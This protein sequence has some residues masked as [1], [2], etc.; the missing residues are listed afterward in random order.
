[1]KRIIKAINTIVI[2]MLV[3]SAALAHNP[4]FKAFEVDFKPNKNQGILTTDKVN[5]G[6]NNG[7]GLK[8]GCIKFPLD[9]IG[10]ITFALRNKVNN[11]NDSGTQ[12]VITK[13]ELSHQGFDL[14]G[15]TISD[16]GIFEGN[17][18]PWLV[19]SFPAFEGDDDGIL[20]EASDPQA[21]GLTRV[22]TLNLNSN[23]GGVQNIW[24]RVSV[25]SCGDDPVVL[26]S[27]PRLENGGMN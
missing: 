21:D 6:C 24:Y 12:W 8:K 22:T 20:F 25:S 26:V 16:K 19:D 27:D 15:G 13:I 4:A 23:T 10:A 3:S 9:S 18:P 17:L 7:Q 14:P 1:M 11:C 2:S 5:Q